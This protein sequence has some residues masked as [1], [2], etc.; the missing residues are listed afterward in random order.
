MISM[1]ISIKKLL[2]TLIN[3]FRI[4]K[5]DCNSENQIGINVGTFEI[6]VIK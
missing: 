4:E 6:K 1:D 5:N 3:Y 2:K